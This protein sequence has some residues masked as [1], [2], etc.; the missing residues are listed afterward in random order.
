LLIHSFPS[1]LISAT[2]LRRVNR[3]LI[4]AELDGEMVRCHLHDPGRLPDILSQKREILLLERNGKRK[5]R[6][7]VIA[8]R[9]GGEWVFIHSGYHSMFAERIVDS[10]TLQELAGYKIARREFLY[11]KSRID[12]LLSND[13]RALLEVKGCTLVRDGVALFPDAPTERGRR[14]VMEMLK[15]MEEGY[16]TFI[17]FLVMRNAVK[18]SPNREVDEGFAIALKEAVSR[19]TEVMAARLGFDGNN[20]F[21][22]GRIPVSI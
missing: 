17:L 10:D 19:G 1:G 13:T 3:F 11:G 18:F 12:F 20:V 7:D 9:M 6:Y 8:A 15:A 5:T 22:H 16:K 21:Y 2:F 4:E 14:H